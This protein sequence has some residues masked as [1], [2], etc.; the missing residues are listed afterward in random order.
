VNPLVNEV[1][2]SAAAVDG[3]NNFPAG[4]K[5]AA[6]SG[7]VLAERF[8]GDAEPAPLGGPVEPPW[9]LPFAL[10]EVVAYCL[11][12]F[13]LEFQYGPLA[14]RDAALHEPPVTVAAGP[15]EPVAR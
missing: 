3:I 12:R 7:V 15:R 2:G 4:I 1:V 6:A 5:A 9:Q 14:L 10:R 8:E 11:A 13:V